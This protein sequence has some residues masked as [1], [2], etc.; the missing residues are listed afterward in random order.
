MTRTRH[1]FDRLKDWAALPDAELERRIDADAIALLRRLAWLMGDAEQTKRA[2][3]PLDGAGFV[4][5]VRELD[6]RFREGARSLG[7]ALREAEALSERQD[8]AGMRRVYERFMARCGSRFHR[9]VAK[10]RLR[11]LE[12]A[13]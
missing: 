7:A 10:F 9:D 4:A 3:L 12:G 8:R 6:R 11:R 13:G 2:T 1:D 5:T